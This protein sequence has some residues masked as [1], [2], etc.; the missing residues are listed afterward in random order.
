MEH[1]DSG[2]RL[3]SSGKARI[4][5]GLPM[6]C[7]MCSACMCASDECIDTSH[8]SDWNRITIKHSVVFVVV[9]FRVHC[10]PFVINIFQNI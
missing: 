6:V 4:H 3:L 5:I 8:R 7:G 1:R 9:L 2:P 10:T